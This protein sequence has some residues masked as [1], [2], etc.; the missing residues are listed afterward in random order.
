VVV[1][2]ARRRRSAAEDEAGELRDLYFDA[3][4]AFVDA[5]MES[6]YAEIAARTPAPAMGGT[7]PWPRALKELREE[8]GRGPEGI[9]L[10]SAIAGFDDE[11]R[12]LTALEEELARGW[13]AAS[14]VVHEVLD[15]VGV[16]P[17]VGDVVDLINSGI[18]VLEDRYSDAGLNMAG[19]L[20]PRM[21][22]ALKYAANH[23]DEALDLLRLTGN[24]SGAYATNTADDVLE[25][26]TP[27]VTSGH[28]ARHLEGTGLSATE[29][30]SMILQRV[31]VEVSEAS[32]TSSF[33][34]HAQI[35]GTTIEYRAHTLPDGTINVGA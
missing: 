5:R 3:Q 8:L 27:R 7:D 22:A 32:T 2:D 23:G 14:D 1:G 25:A 21:G 16:V 4:A 17:G 31:M 33:R 29:V 30:E 19:M 11:I 24:T 20:L 9:A 34:M 28:G 26:V 12:G 10:S 35:N 18:G 13:S 15:V 6:K